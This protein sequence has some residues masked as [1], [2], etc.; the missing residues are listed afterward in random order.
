MSHAPGIHVPTTEDVRAA[1]SRL[2]RVAHR[3]PVLASKK[4][5]DAVGAHVFFKCES[6]QRMG[7]F[8]FRGA[9]NAIS[10]LASNARSKGVITYSS[11]NHAQAVA[12]SASL[13]GVPS[14]VLMPGDA[15]RVKVEATRGYGAH[16]R[17]YDRVRDDREAICSELARAH[18]LSF[19]HP[20]DDAH[21]IAGQGSAAW[22]L[23]E[24][25]GP[26]DYLVTALGGGGLLAGSA[27]AAHAL[28]PGCRVIGVEPASS[29][30]GMQSLR[31]GHIVHVQAPRSI[32]EGAL[33][34]H[35]G[36]RNFEVMKR[37]VHDVVTVGDASIVEAMRHLAQTMKL[38]VE[39]TGALPLA[40]L[41]APSL[42][43]RSARVGV[44]LSGGNV[45]LARYGELLS[46][47]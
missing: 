34:T 41:L 26:L 23:F 6:F 44:I 24:D 1:A 22:E 37:H 40:G 43:V 2:Q 10:Q 36:V 46:T 4:L 3:T 15:P 21:V 17:L 27:L 9:Y 42:D 32:A 8:K 29:D 5:D 45:D 25:V 14:T 30:D 12:L 20:F 31:A 16:V 19:I 28:S 18:S 39:P 7:A 11:G 38:V 47:T 33:G 35:V 13:L